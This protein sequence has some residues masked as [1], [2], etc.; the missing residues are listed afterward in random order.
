MRDQTPMLGYL[1]ILCVIN[2]I[3]LRMIATLILIL[4]NVYVGYRIYVFFS[5]CK[6]IMFQFNL[7]YLQFTYTN[8]FKLYSALCLL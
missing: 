1:C 5:M 7:I 3:K 4:C 8:M 6:G 2:S